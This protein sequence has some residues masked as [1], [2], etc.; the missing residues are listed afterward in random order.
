MKI[1]CPQSI[2]SISISA[3]NYNSINFFLEAHGKH[4]LSRHRFCIC[5]CG[6]NNRTDIYRYGVLKIICL[7]LKEIDQ[8]LKN[9]F[10]IN[11]YKNTTYEGYHPHVAGW[12]AIGYRKEPSPNLMEVQLE[13]CTLYSLYSI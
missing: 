8:G 11:E 10:T 3:A 5:V 13:V 9:E 6:F 12:G 2:Y 4:Y 1:P 7:P